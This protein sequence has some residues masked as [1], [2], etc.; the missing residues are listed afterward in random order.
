MRCRCKKNNNSCGPGCQCTGCGNM[1]GHT[2]R[3]TGEDTV[4]LET[5]E[6]ADCEEQRMVETSDEEDEE[7]SADVDDVIRAVFGSSDSEDDDDEISC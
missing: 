6:N 3:D 2:D 7:E 5:E 4:Q 1:G